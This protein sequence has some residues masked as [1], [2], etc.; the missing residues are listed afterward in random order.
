MNE[1]VLFIYMSIEQTR[2]VTIVI[3]GRCGLVVGFG[4]FHPEGLRFESHSSCHVGT[5]GKSFTRSCLH[6]VIWRPTLA[7]L[8]LNSTPEITCYHPSIHTMFEIPT[9]YLTVQNIKN[10]KIIIII[11][12][13]LADTLN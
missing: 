12:L 4:T 3:T 2:H 8:R 13:D 11:T 6:I 10:T 5:L 9:A 1:S 7:A